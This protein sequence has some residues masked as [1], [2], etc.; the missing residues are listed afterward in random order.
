MQT[1]WD[2]SRTAGGQ[3][4]HHRPAFFPV[5]TG[6]VAR[7]E[8]GRLKSPRQHARTHGCS[9]PAQQSPRTKA[10]ISESITAL[11]GPLSGRRLRSAQN[12]WSCCGHLL[13]PGPGGPLTGAPAQ[14]SNLSGASCLL[15]LAVAPVCFLSSIS[16][17]VTYLPGLTELLT[18]PLN[19]Q[20]LS[21]RELDLGVG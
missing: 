5:D 4:R 20:D 11:R 15:Q 19:S 8:Q 10:H 18:L 9:P 3:A 13:E 21:Q 2:P 16:P 14:S 12:G 7:P 6:G 1:C 17:A